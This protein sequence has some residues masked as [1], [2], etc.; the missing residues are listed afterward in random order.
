MTETLWAPWRMD[1]ILGP[2]PDSCVFCEALKAGAEYFSN[3]YILKVERNA[4]VIMNRYP[5]THAHIMIVPARHVS[6]LEDLSTEE[7]RDLFDL[8][9]RSQTI[10]RR[11]FEPQGLNIG[12][13]IGTA[14]GAGIKDHLHVHVVPRWNGD[15]NFMPMLADSRCMPEHISETY[16]KLLPAFTKESASDK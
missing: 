13:N 2:K 12:M 15:T 7:H 4:Y 8:V 1:Y 3:N 14:G 16:E 10:I 6:A 5:Y 9:V 11:S